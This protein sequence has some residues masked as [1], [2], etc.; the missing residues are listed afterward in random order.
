M[1]AGGVPAL[2]RA[3]GQV[4][5]RNAEPSVM[6]IVG[7]EFFTYCPAHLHTGMIVKVEGPLQ[8]VM[9]SKTKTDKKHRHYVTSA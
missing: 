4:V 8:N 6:A 3:N 1:W 5:W 7:E 9:V 2:T